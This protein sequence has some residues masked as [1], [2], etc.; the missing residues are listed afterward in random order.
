MKVA[1]WEQVLAGEIARHGPKLMIDDGWKFTAE[2]MSNAFVYQQARE[3]DSFGALATQLETR[4]SIAKTLGFDW[5]GTPSREAFRRW[6]NDLPEPTQEFLQEEAAPTAWEDF[7]HHSQ[8][9]GIPDIV[10]KA[11][12]RKLELE[13]KYAG[14]VDDGEVTTAQQLAAVDEVRDLLRDGIEDTRDQ[15]KVEHSMPDLLSF[16]GA[17]GKTGNFAS[18]V[19]RTLNEPQGDAEE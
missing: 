16:I 2:Q 11:K 1:G 17:L 18:D 7:Q 5:P 13:R 10:R 9:F 8:G 12:T 3:L 19:L 4:P 15:D 14:A 6:W